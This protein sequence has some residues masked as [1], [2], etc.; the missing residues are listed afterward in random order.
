[1]FHKPAKF[2]IGWWPLILLF[3][4]AVLVLAECRTIYLNRKTY[5]FFS[6]FLDS[7]IWSQNDSPYDSLGAIFWAVIPRAAFTRTVKILQPCS[8][9]LQQK[10]QRKPPLYLLPQ[11]VTFFQFFWSYLLLPSCFLFVY[12]FC[13]YLLYSCFS[14]LVSAESSSIEP[15]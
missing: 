2:I 4:V 5:W 15:H 6:S 8:I 10:Q 11:E 14:Y 7:V 12:C 9:F 3:W 13:L 1:M